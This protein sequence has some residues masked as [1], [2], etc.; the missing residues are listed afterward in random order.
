MFFSLS[1]S[2]Y[3]YI[4]TYICINLLSH[5]T[6]VIQRPPR[7]EVMDVLRKANALDAETKEPKITRIC[8]GSL[9]VPSPSLLYFTVSVF[10]FVCDCC[11]CLSCC[12]DCCVWLLFLSFSL[13]SL[14]TVWGQLPA[15]CPLMHEDTR[16]WKPED[17]QN[18]GKILSCLSTCIM[19]WKFTDSQKAASQRFI[20]RLQ[21]IY[22]C[23]GLTQGVPDTLLFRY[24]RPFYQPS[25]KRAP[26]IPGWSSSLGECSACRFWQPCR[27]LL[28]SGG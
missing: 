2:I 18:H 10:V 17:V 13:F 22:G 11:V 8:Y 1:L 16:R 14:W 6:H 24:L 3:G 26:A 4:Y 20:Y 23:V 21:I 25:L 19:R 9:S 5:I 15:P 7:P 12:L 28:H 27:F